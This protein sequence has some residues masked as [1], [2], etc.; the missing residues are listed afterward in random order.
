MTLFNLCDN[1]LINVLEFLSKYQFLKLYLL[2]SKKT[3]TYLSS[4][5]LNRYVVKINIF[6]SIDIKL[7]VIN[8]NIISSSIRL[9]DKLRYN[10]VYFDTI[11]IGK[12]KKHINYKYTYKHIK[13]ILIRDWDHKCCDMF[14]QLIDKHVIPQ[15]ETIYI[16]IRGK[17][18][19]EHCLQVICENISK[20]N[21]KKLYLDRY[22]LHA[23][24]ICLNHEL[25]F[26]PKSLIN[27]LHN[28]ITHPTTH[29]TTFMLFFQNLLTYNIYESNSE[30]EDENDE[31]DID[32]SLLK[33]AINTF[34]F[35]PLYNYH[36]TTL[37]MLAIYNQHNQHII[38]DIGY[39]TSF[40]N[41]KE[42][43]LMV[44]S[45]TIRLDL[46]MASF[47][48]LTNLTLP[49]KIA[50]DLKRELKEFVTRS[51]TNKTQKCMTIV[52][53]N[54]ET[55]CFDTTFLWSNK[56]SLLKNLKIFNTE[57]QL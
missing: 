30:S 50:N 10:S 3:K 25:H 9:N 21:L 53:D 24:D 48:H 39:F 20:I 19:Y 14:Y 7:P 43:H 36:N 18:E 32:H 28:I 17:Q 47:Q 23:K 57:L 38:P 13:H 42:L 35:E 29:L 52:L 6:R 11:T 22:P 15:I 46:S 2:V 44:Y 33:Q 12:Y 5:I 55:S 54:N 27:T 4:N 49:Y 45:A 56:N 1:L 51:S 34:I 37:N 40:T 8:S 26:S 41:L 16:S 31:L